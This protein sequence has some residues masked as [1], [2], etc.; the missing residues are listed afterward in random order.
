MSWETCLEL[1]I[2]G[3]PVPKARARTVRLGNG[4][5]GTYTPKRTATYE[6]WVRQ[7]ALGVM[8]TLPHDRFPLDEPLKLD[9][10]LFLAQPKKPKFKIAPATKPDLDNCV[11]ALVDGLQLAAV[12]VDD[13]RICSLVATKGFCTRPRAEVRLFRWRP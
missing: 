7:C 5:I 12:F 4:A 10:R 3:D 2:E 11:K 6:N 9:A 1:L 8:A 13:S